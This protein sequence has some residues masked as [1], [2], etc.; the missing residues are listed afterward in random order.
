MSS[1]RLRLVPLLLLVCLLATMPLAVGDDTTAQGSVP[2]GEDTPALPEGPPVQIQ[3]VSTVPPETP[4]GVPTEAPNPN[5]PPPT[6][7]PNPNEPP[8]TEEPDPNEPPPTGN[9]HRPTSRRRQP[10]TSRMGRRRPICRSRSRHWIFA[11][12]RT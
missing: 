10:R 1:M 11:A 6:A 3:P 2:A 4:A 7:D 12:H 9:S 8:P 5:E